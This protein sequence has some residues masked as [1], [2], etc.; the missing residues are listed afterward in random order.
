MQTKMQQFHWRKLLARFEG[1]GARTRVIIVSQLRSPNFHNRM[2]PVGGSLP[3][4]YAMGVEIEFD[5]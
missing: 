5:A 1:L 4:F 3:K 2:P